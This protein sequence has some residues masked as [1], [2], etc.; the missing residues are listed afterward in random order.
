VESFDIVIVGAG[1][2]AP[3]IW[4]S[5]PGRSVAVIEQNRVGGESPFTAC[6]PSKTMLRSGRVWDLAAAD[7]EHASL[8]TGR[9]PPAAAYQEAVLR[10]DKV[11]HHRD[12]SAQAD[13]LERAGATLI[14]G[15][16]QVT[17]PGVVD[18]N[19][20]EI[21][22]RELVLSTGSEPSRP[23]IDGLDSIPAWTSDVAMS[24]SEQPDRMLVIGGGPVGCELAFLFATFGTA[25]TV[26]QRN[27]RLA[28]R[29][30]EEAS[31]A[32]RTLLEE[33]GVQVR[34][35]SE[36]ERLERHGEGA[37]AFVSD[38]SNFE[39]DQVVLAAGRK[40]LSAGLGLDKLGVEVSPTGEVAVDVHCRVQGADHVWAI[41]DVTGVA[42]FTHTAHYQGRVV[43][44]NL[45]GQGL[46]ADY[47]AVP[48]AVY[49]DP[50]LVAVGHTRASARAEGIEPLVEHASMSEPVRSLTEGSSTGWLTLLADPRRGVLIGA[51]AMGGY[52]E[53]WISEVSLAIRAEV[54]AWVA[55]DVI[56]PF[57]TFSEV[58]EAPLR[59]MAAELPLQPLGDTPVQRP[60]EST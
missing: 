24:T 14:R 47:R 31:D 16:G 32:L 19:G 59:R 25:V 56:H 49:T 48:R 21:G 15:R 3:L 30:E 45:A 37:R 40:P 39:V 18:V 51:T 55:A 36:V 58:L 5:V 33:R 44:A 22:Y 43:A 46:R 35:A 26:V 41:G 57:P 23:E 11:V 28:S 7:S 34:L 38:G 4:G 1:I 2:G 17:R 12:D 27:T 9:V 54:P 29:E 52:A 20:R 53:E 13:K 42:P 8:F 10:R 6:T 60:F 50:V